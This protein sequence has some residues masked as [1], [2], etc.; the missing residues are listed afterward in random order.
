MSNY[1]ALVDRYIA[2][3]NEADAAQR[4]RLIAETWSEDARYVDP[5]MRGEGHD[6]IDALVRGVQAKFP[7][8]RFS[9]KGQAEMVEGCLRFSWL[10]GPEDGE[11]LAGGTDFAS[12]VDGRL[13][14][15]TGFIDFAPAMAA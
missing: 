15:V 11:A 1:D 6:G 7:G 9:R 8:L 10:L 4:R 12:V 13:R 2:I 14:S 3:W 5:M